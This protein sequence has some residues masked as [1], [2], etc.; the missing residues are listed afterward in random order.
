LLYHVNSQSKKPESCEALK[1]C[2]FGGPEIHFTSAEAAL[3]QFVKR[4]KARE[5]KAER[6][7]LAA[8]SYE[9]FKYLDDLSKSKVLKLPKSNPVNAYRTGHVYDRGGKADLTLTSGKVAM[10]IRKDLREAVKAEELPPDL[11]YRVTTVSSSTF[12][13]I[14]GMKTP[15]EALMNERGVVDIKNYSAYR[16]LETYLEVLGN[17]WKIE[18][19]TAS[20]P[21]MLNTC[22]VDTQAYWRNY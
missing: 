3:A 16:K 17:Q 12:R 18:A 14:V 21:G 9:N 19:S 20:A 5:R 1:R 22:S 2:S 6:A 7:R 11:E 4:E 8:M 10:A 15:T 13:I